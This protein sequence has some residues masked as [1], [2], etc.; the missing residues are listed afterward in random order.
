VPSVSPLA[1]RVRV[2][3]PCRPAG[4]SSRFRPGGH[5]DLS[6]NRRPFGEVQAAENQKTSRPQG[7]KVDPSA[8]PPTFGDAALW[9]TGRALALRPEVRLPAPWPPDATPA[10]RCCPVSLARCAGAYWQALEARGSVRRLTG[11]FV[12]SAAPAC[13]NRWFSLPAPGV[14][15]PDHSPYSDVPRSLGAR[16]RRCQTVPH[17]LRWGRRPG[18]LRPGAP[19][20]HAACSYQYCSVWSVPMSCPLSRMKPRPSAQAM[21]VS[22]MPGLPHRKMSKLS[23]VSGN[24][25]SAWIWSEAIRSC[26]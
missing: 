25:V 9:P 19:G 16:P 21:T 17:P 15:R 18:R 3:H 13:T 5:C 26:R 24:P 2:R 22:I 10:D 12:P 4:P 11:P 1:F 7:R 14:T 23:G 8:V 6:G 20:Q